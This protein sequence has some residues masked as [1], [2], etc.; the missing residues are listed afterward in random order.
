MNRNWSTLLIFSV[1][2]L[3]V[4]ALIVAAGWCLAAGIDSAL[5]A[6]SGLAKVLAARAEESRSLAGALSR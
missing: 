3:L 1:I 6:L 2:G 4:A 5:W